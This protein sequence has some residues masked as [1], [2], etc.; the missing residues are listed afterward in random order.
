MQYVAPGAG[1]DMRT[2]ALCFVVLALVSVPLLATEGPLTGTWSSIITYWDVQTLSEVLDWD[3]LL[4]VDYELAPLTFG[5]SITS[6]PAYHGLMAAGPYW[7]LDHPWALFFDACGRIG[8]FALA[9]DIWFD[10]EDAEFFS[11][12]TGYWFSFGAVEVF[13]MFFVD[14]DDWQ[15]GSLINPFTGFHLADSSEYPA[16]GAGWT[17]GAAGYAGRVALSFE[18]GF[19]ALTPLYV[20]DEFDSW[21]VYYHKIHDELRG[22]GWQYDDRP[23]GT[24]NPFRWLGYVG[25][26]DT[27]QYTVYSPQVQ[28][29]CMTQLSFV[30]LKATVPF[31]C[32]NVGIDLSITGENGFEDITFETDFFDIP[33][34]PWL[35]VSAALNFN[36]QTKSFDGLVSLNLGDFACLTPVF[37]VKDEGGWGSFNAFDSTVHREFALAAL[38]LECRL[39]DVI[40][41]AGSNLT[42]TL[43]FLF[44]RRGNLIRLPA[45]S[46][47]A[48]PGTIPPIYE[49]CERQNGLYEEFIGII[50]G[51]DTCC[52]EGFSLSA[53]VWFDDKDTGYAPHIN[54]PSDQLFDVAEFDL[55]VEFDLTEKVR[56]HLGIEST[57]DEPLKEFLF[58]IDVAF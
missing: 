1:E 57:E 39:G 55:D 6:A 24:W 23:M 4:D 53:F 25:Y 43:N 54:P 41:R 22:F 47:L 12:I 48:A 3:M 27:L 40:V 38:H 52:G 58:G 10:F 2:V 17:I 31:C 42:H 26:D 29:S 32:A 34:L 8:S 45:D 51:G 46:P 9:S 50:V 37:W 33:N 49:R 13:G 5:M 44:D 56:I 35:R 28:T 30:E 7:T 18:V 11:W 20:Y 19:N 36:P 21:S 15:V 16:T 14:A